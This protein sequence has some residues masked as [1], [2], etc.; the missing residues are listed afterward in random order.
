MLL[1]VFFLTIFLYFPDVATPL[2]SVLDFFFFYLGIS[3]N[4]F[5]YHKEL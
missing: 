2:Y 5:L 4:I 3:D 1:L